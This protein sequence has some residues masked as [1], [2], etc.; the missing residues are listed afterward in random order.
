MCGEDFLRFCSRGESLDL[1]RSLKLVQTRGVGDE[2]GGVTGS[3]SRWA[4]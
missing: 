1:V 4:L 3:A 2:V